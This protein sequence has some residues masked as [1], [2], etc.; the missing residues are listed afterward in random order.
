[1][2]RVNLVVID[3]SYTGIARTSY[4]GAERLASNLL[5]WPYPDQ[6]PSDCSWRD[7][8]RMRQRIHPGTGIPP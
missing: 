8:T 1:M 6:S 3:H 4:E 2:I 5:L 7:A